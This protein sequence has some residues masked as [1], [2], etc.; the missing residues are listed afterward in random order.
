MGIS[1][2]RSSRVQLNLIRPSCFV[3]LLL[4]G[5]T[6]QLDVTFI[7]DLSGS[8]QEQKEMI[9]NFAKRVVY[10]LDMGFDRTRIATVAFDTKIIDT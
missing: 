3:F 1:E 2:E 7:L 6:R 9:V 4:S 10:G 8:V 5:C